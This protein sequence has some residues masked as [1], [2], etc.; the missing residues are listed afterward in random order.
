MSYAIWRPAAPADVTG[1]ATEAEALAAVRATVEARG[2]GSV[3]D[4]VL[5]RVPIRGDW[6]TIAEGEQLVERAMESPVLA[7]KPRRRRTAA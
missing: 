1:F 2:R 7:A 4:W 5:V 3:A 6:R